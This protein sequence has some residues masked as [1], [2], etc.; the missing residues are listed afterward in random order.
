MKEKYQDIKPKIIQN[1][2]EAGTVN[3]INI[4]KEFIRRIIY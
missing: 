1:I 2:Q 4:L 3:D